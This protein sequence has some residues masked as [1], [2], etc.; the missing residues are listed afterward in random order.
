MN[1][2]LM[3]MTV[4]AGFLLAGCRS[5]SASVLGGEEAAPSVGYDNKPDMEDGLMDRRKR[6]EAPPAPP[7]AAKIVMKAEKKSLMDFDAKGGGPG[8]AGGMANLAVP[9]QDKA[10][11]EADDAPSPEPVEGGAA[12]ATAPTRAW[13]PETFLFNPLV[14]TDAEGKAEVPVRVPDR[15]TNWRVLAL[16]HSRDG[17]QA[18]AVTTFRGTLPAYVDPVVPGFLLAGDEVRLPVQVVNTTEKEVVES[19][20]IEA[21]NA[22]LEFAAK[23]VKV[24][25]GGN[26][27]EYATL[28]ADAPGTAV[29]KAVLGAT[30]AVVRSIPVQPTGKLV[31]IRKGG[32]LANPR[33]VA[34]EGP[35]K[36]DPK[37]A[38]AR[39]TVYPGALALLRSELSTASGR[40]G[41]A[42]A[43]YALALGGRADGLLK[44]LGGEPDAQAIRDLSIIASQRAIREGMRPSVEASAQLTEAALSH[45]QNPV[46][47]RLSER[48]ADYLARAQ[49]PDGT[50]SGANG[51]TL[52]RLLVTTADCVRA[53]R[54]GA[55]AST[56]GRQRAA[57]ATIKASGAFER[58]IEMV[59][60]AYT[61]A[62][63]L[64]SGAVQGTLADKLRDRVRE[65]VAQNEDGSRYLPVEAGV[66]RADG[67][68]PST[69]ES[70]A[71]AVLA[72]EGDAKATWR[73]D[74]GA[75]LLA[76]YSPSW[77]W[78]DGKTNLVALRAVLALFK[79]P[80][81]QQV[82]LT[83]S[84]DGKVLREGDFNAAQ[85][86][87]VVT[88]EAPAPD[89]AGKHTWTVKAEP[90]VPGLGYALTLVTYVPWDKQDPNKGLELAVALPPDLAVGKGAEV[91]LEAS[92]PSGS[93][94]MRLRHALPAGVQPDRPSLEA[95]LGNGLVQ[96]FRT[97]DGAV[98]FDIGP[99]SPGQIV[100]LKYRVVPTLAG[101]LHAGASWIGPVDRPELAY[102]VPP[103]AW[104]VK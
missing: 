79:D 51:W 53:L 28:R 37:S 15:L 71:L 94:T 77:G 27:V 20:R 85:L 81:P 65:A 41:T 52:Q 72:L 17:A 30:D 101:T 7:R 13:F 90:A 8:A 36:L 75:T 11:D 74:L 25:P 82:K 83:L 78:G 102:F 68:V 42:E 84:L 104:T 91:S 97:E 61:A 103:A 19:L 35:E 26:A 1:R 24:P 10:Q 73:A 76:A 100:Q 89:A 4:V 18:G 12:S 5:R 93:E 55:S 86:K 80:V 38:V 29:L 87:D 99:R 56:A 98:I 32:S 92:A 62:A 59:K 39:L 45:A 43:A 88:L 2:S 63:I 34:L 14:V 21:A 69:I 16:A 46:M 47:S 23:T 95:L 31:E 40:D 49:R 67:T 57:A 33:D 58:N 64:A 44:A 48:L 54:A 96:K 60:D 70:T 6:K 66:V 9:K 3:V 50:F 22:A